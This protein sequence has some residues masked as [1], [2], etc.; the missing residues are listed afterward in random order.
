MGKNKY[1]ILDLTDIFL[2]ENHQIRIRTTMQIYWDYIFF[3]VGT[4]DV[5]T[6]VHT[7]QPE[8]A[9]LHYR[10]FSRMYR[11]GGRY[12]PFWFDYDDVSPDPIWRDLIG[13]YT[14]YGDVKELLLEP[15]SKYIITN[16]GDE[17]TLEFDATQSPEL[18]SGWKRD[19]IIYTNGWLKDGD[20]NTA[21]G[22]T[23]EPLPFSGMSKY[24]YDSDESY[25]DSKEYQDY[26]KSYNTRKVTTTHLQQKLQPNKADDE[27]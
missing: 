7:L 24:P 17:I 13:N 15:D 4:A 1:I 21:A 5:P 18:K 16:A 19:F 9:D 2:S 25:P 8:N 23:V 11:K 27:S 22:K 10:G 20:L 12:G 6:N 3:T 14:R 26:I